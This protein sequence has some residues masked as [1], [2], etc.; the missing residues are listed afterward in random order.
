MAKTTLTC[1]NLSN[2]IH[3]G[4]TDKTQQKSQQQHPWSIF[5]FQ[6]DVFSLLWAQMGKKQVWSLLLALLFHDAQL[7]EI[8]LS[9]IPNR[10]SVLGGDRHCS[11]YSSSK[12]CTPSWTSICISKIQRCVEFLTFCFGI[13]LSQVINVQTGKKQK[14]GIHTHILP[15]YSEL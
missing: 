1:C 14:N 3:P 10:I 13:F 8:L 2:P 12:K 5:D 15:R 9:L 6:A 7:G 11:V 4:R